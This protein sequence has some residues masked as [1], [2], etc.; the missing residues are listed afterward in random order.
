MVTVFV[1]EAHLH[2]NNEINARGSVKMTGCAAGESIPC[3]F[4]FT[5]WHIFARVSFLIFV[6][7]RCFN[8]F[9]VTGTKCIYATHLSACTLSQ[10][11]ASEVSDSHGRPSKFP[12]QPLIRAH[13]NQMFEHKATATQQPCAESMVVFMPLFP[14][15][16]RTNK[17]LTEKGFTRPCVY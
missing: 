11:L 4:I 8:L 14:S 12:K 5:Q 2:Q 7:L 1:G 17:T 13:K 15:I 10:V 16:L 9:E 6:L 3:I